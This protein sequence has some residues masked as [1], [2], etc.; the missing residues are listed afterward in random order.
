MDL[1]AFCCSKRP[2]EDDQ[3]IIATLAPDSLA[4][5]DDK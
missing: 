5:S 3:A 2:D 1:F 4:K